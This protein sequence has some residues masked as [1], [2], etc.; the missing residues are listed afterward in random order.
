MTRP[1]VAIRGVSQRFGADGAGV[2]A[3]DGIDLEIPDGQF[4]AVVGPS[5]CGKSTLLSLIAGLRAPSSGDGLL[6]RRADHRARCR[7]RSG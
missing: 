4:V 6:R 1:L 7:A 3:L 5:G 2:T